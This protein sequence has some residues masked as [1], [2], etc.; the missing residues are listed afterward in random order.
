MPRENNSDKRE[1]NNKPKYRS[2]YLYK[3][4][5]N[6]LIVFG[7]LLFMILWYFPPLNLER[8]ELLFS[9]TE[10]EHYYIKL[11]TKVLKAT[12]FVKEDCDPSTQL[13]DELIE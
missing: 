11:K 6:K 10:N 13:S 7:V 5:G 2:S 1:D 9:L 3:E 4:N 8:R 12:Y